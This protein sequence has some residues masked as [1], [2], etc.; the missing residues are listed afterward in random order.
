[1]NNTNLFFR[2]KLIL[3]FSID[4]IVTLS[5]SL[6]LGVFK[7]FVGA[8]LGCYISFSLSKFIDTYSK[9]GGFKL[10][11]NFIINKIKR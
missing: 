8:F 11:D 5:I 9:F 4:I 10:N 1:M 7:Y 3:A 6:I 2:K